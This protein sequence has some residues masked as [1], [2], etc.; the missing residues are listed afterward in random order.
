ME[1]IAIGATVVLTRFLL[2]EFTNLIHQ[3]SVF[4][5]P[6]ILS[7]L[8]V[9]EG[10][11][12]GYPQY[13]SLP[14][15]TKSLP[16]ANWIFATSVSMIFAWLTVM[17]PAI[18]FISFFI[19]FSLEKTYYSIIY[20]ALCGISFGAIIGTAQQFVLRK[21]YLN[22]PYWIFANALSWMLS[23]LI[24]FFAISWAN[25]LREMSMTFIILVFACVI[26]GFIQG[27]LTGLA[28]HY[29]MEPRPE[30]A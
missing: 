29:L 14:A 25:E 18:F 3:P 28:I 12:I 24:V 11:L 22:S 10:M 16:M 8:G 26:S 4:V 30:H 19:D 9:T 21:H 13:R 5:A 15:F 1:S 2:V 17:P 20:T 23:F 6:I 7:L 27:L